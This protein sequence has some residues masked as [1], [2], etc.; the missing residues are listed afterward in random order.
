MITRRKFLVMMGLIL[1]PFLRLNVVNDQCEKV[2]GNGGG[3]VFPFTFPIEFGSQ[4]TELFG[5]RDWLCRLWLP[6]LGKK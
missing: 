5:C 6:F 4:Q 2:V 1:N 3:I